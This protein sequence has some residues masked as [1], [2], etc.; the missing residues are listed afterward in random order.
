MRGCYVYCVDPQLASHIRA[1]IAAPRQPIPATNSSYR[2]NVTPL[3]RITAEERPHVRAVPLVDLKVAAGTFSDPQSLEA[4]A[5]VWVEVPE[6][7]R[8]QPGLFVAQVM[9]ES[10]NRR[11]PNGS[12]CLF[13]AN[14]MGT[15]A[16]KVVVAQHRSIHDPELG[17]SY[18]IK[19]YSSTKVENPDGSWRHTEIRLS[20]DSNQ[21]TFKPIVIRENEEGQFQIVAEL[22]SVL[23]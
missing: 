2:A 23:T 13:R 5:S 1:R 6:W 11:I 12:W 19:V 22:L 20:P 16:G 18:T 10:M 4:G 17:G 21:A 3:R 7:I 15:R 9:G 14:P 8:P